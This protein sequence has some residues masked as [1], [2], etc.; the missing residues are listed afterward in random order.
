M[1][2]KDLRPVTLFEQTPTRRHKIAN[3]GLFH[4]WGIA[5]E[6]LETSP[7]M[8]AVAIVELPDGHTVSWPVD[9]V[10]F[11]DVAKEDSP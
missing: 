2:P 6:E 7:V 10:R 8:F 5:F 9:L 11:D 4:Q 3:T 1:K